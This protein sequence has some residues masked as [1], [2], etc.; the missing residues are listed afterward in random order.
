MLLETKHLIIRDFTISD[1]SDLYDILG[2]DETMKNCEPAY[3]MAKTK[4]F[5][6]EFCILKNGAVAAVHKET[7][8]VI[9]YILFHEITEKVYEIGW[10]FNKNY[11]QKGYAY[12]SCFEVMRYAFSELNAYKIVAEA[13]DRIKSVGLMEKLGMTLEEVQKEQTNDNFGNCADLYIYGITRDKW[14]AI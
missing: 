8:K 14:Q 12:E 2:D 4:Q 9:G 1:A 3:D 11:W 10:I 7:Q 5:L 13:I 6:R